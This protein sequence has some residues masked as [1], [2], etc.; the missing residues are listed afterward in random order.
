MVYI[1]KKK[2]KKNYGRKLCPLLLSPPLP[3][4]K[5]EVGRW[6]IPVRPRTCSNETRES[7]CFSSTPDQIERVHFSSSPPSIEGKGNLRPVG[8]FNRF[9][10][11]FSIVFPLP[12]P[13]KGGRLAQTGPITARYIDI[14]RP[15]FSPRRVQFYLC[16]GKNGIRSCFRGGVEWKRERERERE[17][18]G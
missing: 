10:L 11:L 15:P 9:N 14:L 4:W 2:K 8:F 6:D 13:P 7:N 12:S 17:R 1:V 5:V 3:N 18:G 16:S